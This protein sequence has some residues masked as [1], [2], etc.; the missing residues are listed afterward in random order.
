MASLDSLPADQRAVLELVLQRGRNYDE[1]AKLLSIDRAGVRQRALAA[2]D[3]IGPHTQ[4]PA[5]RRALIAD[6]LLGQL[7]PRASETVR[8]RLASSSSERNWARML[9]ADLAPIAREPLPE[10]PVAPARAP[11]ERTAEPVGASAAAPSRPQ[12]RSSRVGGAV[13]LGVGALVVIAVVL[14]L[15]LTGGSTTH[16]PTTSTTTGSGAA[17]STSA[18]TTPTGS[19][20]STAAPQVV[21]A[22]NLLPPASG[23]QAKGVAQVIEVA[24]SEGIVIYATGMPANTKQ[25]FYEV[26]LYNSPSDNYSVG[27]VNPGIGSDGRLQ[28]TGQLPANVAHYKHLVISIETQKRV[29]TPTTVVLQGALSLK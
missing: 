29:K 26:W 19:T 10:I 17:A 18:T 16:S 2:L 11:T 23:S 4:V 15:V 6:Y 21:G 5:E 24:K 14:V 13:L 9:A 25:N 27:F 22:V 7:P 12:R 28:T 1:I 8:E 20:T 3:A